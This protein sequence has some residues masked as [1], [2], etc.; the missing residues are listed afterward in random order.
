MRCRGADILRGVTKLPKRRAQ[1]GCAQPPAELVPGA[2]VL[3]EAEAL[4]QRHDGHAGL[5]DGRLVQ[6][7]RVVTPR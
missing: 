5:W 7:H 4:V 2:K 1:S 3:G 6:L